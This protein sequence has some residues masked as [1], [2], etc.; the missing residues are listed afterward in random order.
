MRPTP[1]LRPEFAPPLDLAWVRAQFPALADGT[2]FMDNAGGG[3]V[4]R[5]VAERIADYLL[6]TNVIHGA[7]NAVSRRS[8]AR[9][10]ETSARMAL[11]MN[12]ADPAEVVMG[13]SSTQLE[14]NLALAMSEQFQAGDEIVVGNAEH[15]ANVEPWER[16][17]RQ[18]GVVVRQWP[19][20]ASTWRLELSDLAPLMTPRTKLVAFTQVSN[21]IG[22]VQDVGAA[23]RFIHERGALVFVDGVAAAPH[24]AIDV[25]GWDVDYYVFSLY[26]V[27]GPHHAALYGRRELL[28]KLKGINHSFFPETLIP[29]KLQPG[30]TN[31]ELGWGCTAVIDYLEE[32]G[33]RHGA[34]AG[35]TPRQRIEAAFAAIAAH[36]SGLCARLLD[37]LATQPRVRLFGPA[38]AAPDA[39]VPTLSFTIDG[40]PSADVPRRLGEM[41]IA[42]RSGD[43]YARHLMPALGLA[44]D[45]GVIRVS[46]AHYNTPEE[47]DRLIGALGGVLAG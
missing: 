11:L 26:K 9:A 37:W 2:V 44:P 18:R 25:T 12:A 35:A 3:Q 8:E 43:F 23:A 22:S 13:P 28:L 40:V 33:A 16:L 32:L 31:H 10:L 7:P 46:L 45:P 47:V 20:N 6:H 27:F 4:L 34:P 39:R 29:Y 42:I 30:N 1:P 36:E 19:L 41:D 21:V 5:T 15:Y 17:A 14:Q 24:R 38:S